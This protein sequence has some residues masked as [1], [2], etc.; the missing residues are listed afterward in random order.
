MLLKAL[1]LQMLY[2]I[3]SER[4]LLEQIDFNFLYRWFVGLKADDKIWDETVFSKNRERLLK[5][6]DCRQA[7]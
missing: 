3:R 6:G 1:F 2:G 5:G 7:V 4:V